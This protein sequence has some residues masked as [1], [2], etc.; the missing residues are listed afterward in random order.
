M[1][2]RALAGSNMWVGSAQLPL[3]EN[4]EY[5]FVVY[6]RDGGTD[7]GAQQVH[8]LAVPSQGGKLHVRDTIGQPAPVLETVAGTRVNSERQ[9]S[10]LCQFEV[11]VPG[12]GDTTTVSLV[13]SHDLLGEWQLSRAIPMFRTHH[14]VF[15]ASMHLPVATD[16]EYQYLVKSTANWDVNDRLVKMSAPLTVTRAILWKPSVDARLPPLMRVPGQGPRG[17]RDSLCTFRVEEVGGEVEAGSLLGIV[18]DCPELG[19]WD[20]SKCLPMEVHK[21]H[22]RAVFTATT[23]VGCGSEVNYKYVI[24]RGPCWE[25]HDGNR[26]YTIPPSV[27]EWQ[28][29]SSLLSSAFFSSPLLSSPLASPPSPLSP[30]PP[31]P[32]LSAASPYCLVWCFGRC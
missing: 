3:G 20:A 13:G 7:L 5:K 21:E 29:S 12:A 2:G 27:C 19:N 28:V 31:P 9:L 22:G 32:S 15:S 30:P 8:N 17:G 25:P 4:L 6:R 18:G 10:C 24:L 23:K 26:R 16:L 14:D 11:T 1:H